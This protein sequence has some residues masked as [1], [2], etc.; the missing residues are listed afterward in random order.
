MSAF[1]HAGHTPCTLPQ[2]S[3]G[4]WKLIMTAKYCYNIPEAN[5][6]NRKRWCPSLLCAQ[7]L[8]MVKYI[9]YE[10]GWNLIDSWKQVQISRLLGAVNLMAGAAR[11]ARLLKLKCFKNRLLPGSNPS[12][13]P[14]IKNSL[15]FP[16]SLHAST[17]GRPLLEELRC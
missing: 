17:S 8:N 11:P 15:C 12:S 4:Q 1:S 10:L 5:A 3:P 7:N 9:K 2:W 6:P 14:E 13:S 16:L